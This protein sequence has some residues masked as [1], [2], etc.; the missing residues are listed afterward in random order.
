MV[1]S[2][3]SPALST[4][5]APTPVAGSTSLRSQRERMVSARALHATTAAITLVV[6][7]T[8]NTTR[9]PPQ[10]PIATPAA[11]IP[12]SPGTT[13]RTPGRRCIAD[14]V[15]QIAIASAPPS[16]AWRMRAARSA[17]GHRDAAPA[18]QVCG[19]LN[20]RIAAYTP[21]IAVRICSALPTPQ[22]RCG[23]T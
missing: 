14:S 23:A 21:A 17:T 9:R 12:S 8:A 13:R 6:A 10:P 5:T 4:T 15:H 7:S 20:A 1:V 11:T 19:G 2:A 3:L 22:R 16:P 18:C